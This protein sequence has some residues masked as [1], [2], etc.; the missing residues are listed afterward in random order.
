MAPPPSRSASPREI[1]QGRVRVFAY[2]MN[3]GKLYALNDTMPQLTGEIV[4]F[5]DASS[6]LAPDAM[7]TLVANFADE[8]VG[9][10]ER[11]VPRAP[12]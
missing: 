9:A 4:A 8:N 6:M 12:R 3:R 2:P 1:G 10:V 5:S 11:R 7:R